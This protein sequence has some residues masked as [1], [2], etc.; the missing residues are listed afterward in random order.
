MLVQLLLLFGLLGLVGI[1][2][3]YCGAFGRCIADIV[4]RRQLHA[5]RCVLLL[6]LADFG[7]N[8]VGAYG[9]IGKGQHGFVARKCGQR[10]VWHNDA[11]AILKHQHDV[12]IDDFNLERRVR[13]V[14]R[15]LV[16]AIHCNDFG[17]TIAIV[18]A[19]MVQFGRF[20]RDRIERGGLCNLA[21]S[22]AFARF[23][24]RNPNHVIPLGLTKHGLWKISGD[25]ADKAGFRIS[26]YLPKRACA[27]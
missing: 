1:A 15:G 11:T 23:G 2:G 22:L 8:F 17:E 21:G 26:P 18:I 19:G 20:M 25:K 4:A 24:P 10:H 16:G 9:A 7:D 27:E 3:L 13:H 5:D 14:Q 12:D 6:D